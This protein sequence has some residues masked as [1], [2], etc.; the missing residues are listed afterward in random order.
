MEPPMDA[1]ERGLDISHSPGIGLRHPNGNV[2]MLDMMVLY[3]SS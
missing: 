1:D 2:Y 3:N